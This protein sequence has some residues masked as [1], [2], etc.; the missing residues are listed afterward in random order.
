MRKRYNTPECRTIHIG[1][2]SLLTATGNTYGNN[3]GSIMYNSTMV[4]A[5]ESD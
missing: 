3:Q 4:D 2:T 1:S 5:G